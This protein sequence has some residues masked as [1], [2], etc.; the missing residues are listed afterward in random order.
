MVKDNTKS[1]DFEEEI[2]TEQTKLE[3]LELQEATIAKKIKA[4][5]QRIKEL[6]LMNDSQKLAQLSEALDKSG[7]DFDGVM[8]LLSQGNGLE[9]ALKIPVQE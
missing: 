1:F 2:K 7:L 5:K 8:A 4:S 3:K 9:E 6:S